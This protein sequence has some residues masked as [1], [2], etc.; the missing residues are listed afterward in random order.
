MKIDVK[1]VLTKAGKIAAPIAASILYL[2]AVSVV[3]HYAV[4]GVDSLW[5]RV[6]SGK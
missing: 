4:K 1:E 6:T 3:T 2:T 5:R